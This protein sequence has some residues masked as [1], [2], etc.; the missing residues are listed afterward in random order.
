ML[1]D[2]S[3]KAVFFYQSLHLF[4]GNDFGVVTYEQHVQIL[5]GIQSQFSLPFVFNK[6]D[7]LKL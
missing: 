5:P 1:L 2:R 7:T 6:R 3:Y 4:D